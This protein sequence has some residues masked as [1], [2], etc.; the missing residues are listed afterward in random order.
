VLPWQEAADMVS[1]IKDRFRTMAADFRDPQG[2]PSPNCPWSDHE[3]TIDG[4]ISFA[5]SESVLTRFTIPFLPTNK[6]RDMF[7]FYLEQHPTKHDTMVLRFICK[8][9]M[10]CTSTCNN[11]R[12][13]AFGRNT[14]FTFEKSY[15][16][17]VAKH[18]CTAQHHRA[19]LNYHKGY[20]ACMQD[21]AR[22]TSEAGVASPAATTAQGNPYVQLR[23]YIRWREQLLRAGLGEW[24]DDPSVWTSPTATPSTVDAWRGGVSLDGFP[25]CRLFHTPL[26]NGAAFEESMDGGH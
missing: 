23:Q 8:L 4:A 3:I 1:V 15:V 22:P 13:S 10:V 26:D 5:P 20:L 2:K 21:M 11:V 17:P 25:T 19:L 9:C 18:A 14:P 16:Q 24:A 6:L 7:D 12:G